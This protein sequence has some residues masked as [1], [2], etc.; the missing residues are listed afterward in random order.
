VFIENFHGQVL[1]GV[2]LEWDTEEE[3]EREWG[4]LQEILDKRA[5]QW[6]SGLRQKLK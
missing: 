2:T 5:S 3:K 1:K 6:S 4:N